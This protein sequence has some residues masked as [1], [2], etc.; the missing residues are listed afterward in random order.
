MGARMLYELMKTDP[1]GQLLLEKTGRD[2]FEKLL[3][4]NGYRV[5]RTRN[6]RRTTRSGMFRFSNKVTGKEIRELNHVWV[7]D[8]TYFKIGTKH[9]YLTSMID[10][11]SRRIL[12][13]SGSNSMQ[14]EMTSIPALKMAIDV[15]NFK[16]FDKL[17][18]HTD[19]GGQYYDEVFLALLKAYDIDSSMGKQASDNPFAERFNG[20]WKNDYLIPWN[21][22]SASELEIML[23]KFYFA[24]NFKRP[25]QSIGKIPPVTFEK[26]ISKIP[27]SQREILKLL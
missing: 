11:Y 7:S 1:E 13:Y 15:R 24:Y 14:A 16:K 23:K 27:V 18:L 21:I 5:N 26:L 8:I 25:H 19:G 10:V 9:Y 22:H 2:K 4:N 12:G 6:H 20:T 17:I 3:L